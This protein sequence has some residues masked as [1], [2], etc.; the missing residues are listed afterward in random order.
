MYT[1]E[2]GEVRIDHRVPKKNFTAI[3]A[4][5]GAVCSEEVDSHAQ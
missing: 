2:T 1:E 3:G 5:G 4:G